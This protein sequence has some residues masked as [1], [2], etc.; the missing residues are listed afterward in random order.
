MRLSHSQ[1][2]ENSQQNVPPFFRVCFQVLA[3]GSHQRLQA[4]LGRLDGRLRVLAGDEPAVAHGSLRP[5]LAWHVLAAKLPE[6]GLRQ[7]KAKL[8]DLLGEAHL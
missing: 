6:L 8:L 5:R 3:D 4:K 1:T 2:T 7:E